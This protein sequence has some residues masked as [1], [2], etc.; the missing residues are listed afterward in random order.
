MLFSAFLNGITRSVEAKTRR[1]IRGIGKGAS[2]SQAFEDEL[3][4]AAELPGLIVLHGLSPLLGGTSHTHLYLPLLE[5][6][7]ATD[8]TGP[9]LDPTLRPALYANALE[10][11]W[12]TLSALGQPGLRPSRAAGSSWPMSARCPP[13]V[14]LAK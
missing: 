1:R 5:A 6:W 8:G 9:L 13:D 11:A 3:V 2:R 4:G 7:D 10:T 14:P 12:G